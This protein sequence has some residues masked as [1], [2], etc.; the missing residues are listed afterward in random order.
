MFI[1]AL[2]FSNFD[3]NLALYP[4]IVNTIYNFFIVIAFIYKF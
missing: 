3:I 4:S 2:L 1:N